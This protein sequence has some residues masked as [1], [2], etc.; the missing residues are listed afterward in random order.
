MADTVTPRSITG[1]S[2]PQTSV[3]VTATVNGTPVEALVDAR[4]LLVYWL[5]EGLGLSAAHVGCNTSHC[6]ACAVL[7]NGAPVKSC[8]LLAAQA[9]G[10]EITTLEGITPPG[11]LHPVQEAFHEEHALQC[12]FCTPGFVITTLALLAR[13]P[14]PTED[15]IRHGLHGNLC[16]CTGYHNIVRAV[17][18][19]A[20]QL[21]DNE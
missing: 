21:H 17:K 20:G 3:A 4:L 14:T 19:A 2:A 8:T 9:D 13:N 15:D 7:L 16:R 5:R 6:G 11:G 12:G 10:A 18:R 1:L